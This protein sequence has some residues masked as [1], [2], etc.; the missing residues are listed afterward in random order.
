MVK[1][2]RRYKE[3]GRLRVAYWQMVGPRKRRG[4]N[5]IKQI[6]AIKGR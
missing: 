3:K 6:R 5:R 1:H 4:K 2:V